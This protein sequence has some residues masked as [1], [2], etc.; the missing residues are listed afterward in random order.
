LNFVS[1]LIGKLI[2]RAAYLTLIILSALFLVF[3]G[4][5][6]AEVLPRNIVWGGRLTDATF[7]PLEL[8]AVVLNLLLMMTGAVTGEFVTAKAAKVIVERTK[9]FLFF[10]FGQLCCRPVF[11]DNLRGPYDACNRALCALPL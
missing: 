8:L 1:R 10:C 3:H 2:L 7:L 5:V 6:I 9:W 4:L 11:P